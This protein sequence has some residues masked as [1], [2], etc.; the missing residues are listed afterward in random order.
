MA[1][2]QGASCTGSR[3][4]GK[5]EDKRARVFSEDCLPLCEA[6]VKH[7]APAGTEG[8]VTRIPRITAIDNLDT[9][10]RVLGYRQRHQGRGPDLWNIG[11]E[12]LVLH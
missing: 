6:Q 3:H 11:Q 12:P 4:G 10:Q 5:E 9:I 2:A 8:Q 7:Q 1:F